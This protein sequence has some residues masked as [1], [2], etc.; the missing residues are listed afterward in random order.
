M[1]IKGA[2]SIGLFR[3]QKYLE[4]IK[5]MDNNYGIKFRGIVIDEANHYYSLLRQ[6]VKNNLDEK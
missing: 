2:K 1:Q 4:Q 5:N 3:L 6:L